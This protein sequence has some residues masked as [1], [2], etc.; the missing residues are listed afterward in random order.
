[1]AW[2]PYLLGPVWEPAASHEFFIGNSPDGLE[3]TRVSGSPHASLNLLI[4]RWFD[5]RPAQISEFLSRCSMETPGF[6]TKDFTGEL[7]IP[8]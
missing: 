7:F 1:M 8:D 2:N 4:R 5:S 6:M 3:A